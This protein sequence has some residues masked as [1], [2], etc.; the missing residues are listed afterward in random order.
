LVRSKIASEWNGESIILIEPSAPT[1]RQSI[2]ELESHQIY[3]LFLGL[4][5]QTLEVLRP[6]GGELVL[7]QVFSRQHSDRFAGKG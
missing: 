6:R 7:N 3:P 4:G 2:T 5:F 1:H